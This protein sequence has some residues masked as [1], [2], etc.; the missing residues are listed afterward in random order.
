MG[1]FETWIHNL[2]Y[3]ALQWL[4]LASCRLI[5]KKLNDQKGAADA[6][7]GNLLLRGC[8]CWGWQPELI[9]DFLGVIWIN[10]TTNLLTN[11]GCD[12][13]AVSA[14][15]FQWLL[16]LICLCVVQYFFQFLKSYMY[17]LLVSMCTQ[18]L[19]KYTQP[20][21]FYDYNTRSD[22]QKILW[23]LSIFLG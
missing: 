11:L 12:P 18:V 20:F 22:W 10:T 7:V 9:F 16:L 23:N 4:W 8:R 14:C 17:T 6:V 21:S 13:N 2:S 3:R 15:F 5:Y 1:V 19:S